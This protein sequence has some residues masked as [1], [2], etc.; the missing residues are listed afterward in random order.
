MSKTRGSSARS[1]QKRRAVMVAQKTYLAH[2]GCMD[3]VELVAV[4][5]VPEWE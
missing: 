3:G 2:A 4:E 5:E 1:C